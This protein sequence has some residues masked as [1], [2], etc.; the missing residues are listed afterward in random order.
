MWA[1]VGVEVGMVV[2]FGQKFCAPV[3]QIV[4]RTELGSD[5]CCCCGAIT[6]WR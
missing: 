2:V 5:C 6:S 4:E 1:K 3:G